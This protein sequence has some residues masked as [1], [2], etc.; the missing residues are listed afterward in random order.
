[1][2]TK[3]FRLALLL[4]AIVQTGLTKE[5]RANPFQYAWQELAPGIWAGIRQDPFE[6]PQEGN[7][8]FVVTGS[9]VLSSDAG[10]TPELGEAIATSVRSVTEKPIT[11]GVLSHWH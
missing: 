4:L 10:G 3:N 9:G 5:A 8:V 6:L 2:T 1:M 7:A 11:H